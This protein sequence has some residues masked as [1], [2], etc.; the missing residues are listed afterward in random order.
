MNNLSDVWSKRF[1][2]YIN[3]LQKY[4]KYIFSGHIAIVIVFV[5]GA[6]GYTYSEWLNTAPKD[7]PAYLV[8]AFIVSILIALSTPVTLMKKA[9]SVYFL[10]LETK[11]GEYLKHALTWTFFSSI[12]VPLAALVVSIPLLTR[13]TGSTKGEI[14]TFL[15]AIL[16]WK[17]WS[18]QTEFQ[19]RWASNGK[20]VWVDYFMRMILL[21]AGLYFLLSGNYLFLLAV[22]IIQV[23]YLIAWKK[24]K[25]EVPFPFDHFIEVE[26][27]RMM[28]FYRFANYFTDVPHIQGMTKRRRWLDM[29]YKL[30]PYEQKHT[31]FY[32]VLRTFIRTND[33]FYLWVRLT[34]LAIGGAIFIPFPIVA[35]IFTSALSFATVIQLR[36]SLTSGDEFR[37]DLLFPINEGTRKKAVDKLIR[38]IQLKQAILV[39]IVIIVQADFNMELMLIPVVML[40]I[41]ELTL[42]VSKI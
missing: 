32:L 3:E 36:Q 26:Q 8:V 18:I 11:L 13:I 2:F 37:M 30:A 23:L 19:Y 39:L 7:F 34:T 9:D 27:A 24:K 4:L 22:I 38:I 16:I 35:I 28:R 12:I 20:D 17:Y 42:R 41:S 14:L 21:F 10:P 33:Y 40:V 31:Q 29:V 6:A 1:V 15:G 25:A 5:I